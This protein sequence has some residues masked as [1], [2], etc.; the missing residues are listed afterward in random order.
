MPW[1][2]FGSQ[3]SFFATIPVSLTN[4]DASVLI[5]ILR[6]DIKRRIGLKEVV[7]LQCKSGGPKI[8]SSIVIFRYSSSCM[9][10]VAYSMDMIGK[11]SILGTCVS[12][13]TCQRT[14][15]WFSMSFSFLVHS[16]M[17]LF[18]SL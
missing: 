8:N 1:S 5:L 3:Y 2:L 6:R 4:R 12:P 16:E 15:S 18:S 14:M 11:S 17:P 9:L 13:K 10:I 7:R